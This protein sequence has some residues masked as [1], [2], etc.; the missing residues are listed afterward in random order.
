MSYSEVR[1]LLD[2]VGERVLVLEFSEVAQHLPSIPSRCRPMFCSIA[3]N[4]VAMCL[5][6]D[7]KASTFLFVTLL[8]F[9]I[10]GT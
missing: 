9:E 6:Q 4:T 8:F 10:D 3:R 7:A 2:E 1:G 5:V